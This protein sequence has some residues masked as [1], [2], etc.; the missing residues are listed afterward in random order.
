M[1]WRQNWSQLSTVIWLRWRLSWNQLSRTRSGRIGAVL[2]VIAAVIALGIALAMG[3]G[4]VVGGVLGL[5]T[6]SPRVM[7]VAWDAVAGIFLFIWMIGVL[8]E[9][10]R[11]ETIDLTR[12]LHLPVSLR[13][14]FVVNYLASHVTL[15]LIV[16][17]PCMLGLCVG[18]LW[19]RGLGMIWLL[20]LV[21]SFIFMVTAW[22]YCLRGWLAAL[23]VNPR[24]R[25]NVVL[26]IT[27][28]AVLLGQLPNLYFNVYLRHAIKKGHPA[29]WPGASAGQP[30]PAGLDAIPA[31]YLLAHNYVPLLWLPNGAMGLAEGNAWPAV[32]GS[33]GAFLLGAVGLSRAYRSTIR[34][35]QGQESAGAVKPRTPKPAAGPRR[36]SLVERTI[37][38]VSEET[39]AL[40]LAF[41]RAWTRAPEVK[42]ALVSYVILLV[43]FGATAIVRVSAVPG[44][45]AQL[46]LA[47]GAVAVTF[48]GM[49]Q[50]M[51]NH[52]GFDRDGF[53]ALV[54]LPASRR[55]LLLAKN[56][57]LAPFPFVLGTIMLAGFKFIGHLPL[58]T[59]LAGA[60]E[61]VGM[62]LVLSIVGNFVSVMV[63]Y[64]VTA[65]TMKPTKAKATTVFFIFLSHL[66]FP[67]VTIPFFLV[68]LAALGAAAWM[69]WAAGAVNMALA[70]LLLAL[71]AV[72][73]RLSLA[74]L[75]QLLER[76]EKA[77]L[78]VVSQE[79]E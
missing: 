71:A 28:T 74:P 72:V 50:L 53:R 9:L 29:G 73:Y 26:A 79:I 45:V 47:P 38:L 69:G 27:M 75:G 63:P 60:L 66:L 11:S 15:S 41:F 17:L 77:I 42:M 3:V 2:T 18:L 46:F 34:F 30:H 35:Y 19:S 64:R 25:R 6:A 58:A 20:P 7:L 49:V 59:V 1:N 13:G 56:L 68:P 65:G 78:L 39:G 54:L 76:R 37:P 10:Q 5:A 70:L 51:F 33:L 32:L 48:F 31:G 57:A 4:G 61:L 36:K 16:F 12:L 44:I 21:A 24:R 23:M 67:V 43:I 8:A 40:T 22:T 62:F 55:H 14:I 52:F